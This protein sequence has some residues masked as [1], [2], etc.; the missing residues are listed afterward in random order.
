M[1]VQFPQICF[2]TQTK[3]INDVQ[4]DTNIDITNTSSSMYQY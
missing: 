1:L 2:P 4:V 3:A